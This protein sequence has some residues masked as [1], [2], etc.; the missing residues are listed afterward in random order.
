MRKI[1]NASANPDIDLSAGSV[2]ATPKLISGL[3][4]MLIIGRVLTFRLVLHLLYLKHL[5]RFIAI[6][7]SYHT[8]A[9][10]ITLECNTALVMTSS[11]SALH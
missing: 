8:R 4:Q 3:A 2:R 1:I 5:N 7:G 6:F 11:V 9:C 10:C